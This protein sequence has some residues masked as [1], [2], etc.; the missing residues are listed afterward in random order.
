MKVNS[1]T[2]AVLFISRT[3]RKRKKGRLDLAPLEAEEAPKAHLRM[4]VANTSTTALRERGKKGKESDFI[5]R[6]GRR[7]PSKPTARVLRPL[8]LF[9]CQRNVKSKALPR[10]QHRGWREDLR[11]G[12]GSCFVGLKIGSYITFRPAVE[13]GGGER[14]LSLGVVAI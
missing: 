5:T 4:G 14:E 9:P 8:V 12:E 3:K 1:R 7:G 2:T 10:C 13:K 11:K 6:E